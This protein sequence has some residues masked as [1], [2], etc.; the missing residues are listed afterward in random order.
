MAHHVR[1]WIL[2]FGVDKHGALRPASVDRMASDLVF[3][4]HRDRP[5][6]AGYLRAQFSRAEAHIIVDR[7]LGQRRQERLEVTDERRRTDRRRHSVGTQLQAMGW[8]IVH[9]EER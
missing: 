2:A 9:H 1:R 8:A 7:R 4:V 6:L 5:E 3:I